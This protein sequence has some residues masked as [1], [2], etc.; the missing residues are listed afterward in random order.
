MFTSKIKFFL[1]NGQQK[2]LLQVQMYRFQPWNL[3]KSAKIKDTLRKKLCFEFHRLK[4]PNFHRLDAE[5]AQF[6]PENRILRAKLCI[7]TAG[8]AI[9]PRTQWFLEDFY[10][11]ICFFLNCIMGLNTLVLV[12]QICFRGVSGGVLGAFWGAFVVF[13]HAFRVKKGQQLTD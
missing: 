8:K 6:R 7:Y 12:F 13:W 11:L 1:R 4:K 9:I 10:F 2:Q 5:N 3:D